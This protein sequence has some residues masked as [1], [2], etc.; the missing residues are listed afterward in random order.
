MRVG[1]MKKRVRGMLIFVMG[2]IVGI[3]TM[4]LMEQRKEAERREFEAFAYGVTDSTLMGADVAWQEY[5]QFRSVQFRLNG[6]LTVDLP[7]G[8]EI[9]PEG[10][11]DDTAFWEMSRE[12]KAI[13]NGN[14][15]LEYDAVTYL[16]ENAQ[17]KAN[18]P[19]V[20]N[21]EADATYGYELS[22]ETENDT[23]VVGYCVPMCNEFYICS[24][25]ES[26]YW[27]CPQNLD[28]GLLKLS[29][30]Y[31]EEDVA[32]TAEK[33]PGI[34][35]ERKP[36]SYDIVLRNDGDKLWGY[37]TMVASLEVWNQGVWMELE[38]LLD[39]PCMGEY[40]QPGESKEYLWTE[41]MLHSL[42]YQVPGIYRI[43]VHGAFEDMGTYAAS[44]PFVVE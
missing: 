19:N 1:A 4:Y 29:R 10:M 35:V 8:G 36:Q 17:I 15:V 2:V 38:T 18:V 31:P 43:V 44:E 24:K 13:S 14:A 26:T 11:V 16:F 25:E 30:T 20:Y 12:S 27:S 41:S 23:I 6:E 39:N 40:I 33:A 5:P 21:V 32:Q 7:R 22:C 42:P 3:L 37:S 34:V 28:F 9:V